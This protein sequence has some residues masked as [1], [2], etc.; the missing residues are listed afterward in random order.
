M[1]SLNR[2]DEGTVSVAA[3]HTGFGNDVGHSDAVSLN[4][5]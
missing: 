5:R 2:T 1:K 3:V 4:I